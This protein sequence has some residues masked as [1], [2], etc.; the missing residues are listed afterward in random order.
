LHNLY[1]ENG[2]SYKKVTDK[3][4]VLALQLYDAVLRFADLDLKTK[5]GLHTKQVSR[6]P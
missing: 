1:L 2:K 5:A 6:K 3:E 4:T